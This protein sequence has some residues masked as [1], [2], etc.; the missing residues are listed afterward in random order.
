[1]ALSGPHL[2]E[3]VVE[4]SSVRNVNAGAGLLGFNP[5]QMTRCVLGQISS[6]IKCECLQPASRDNEDSCTLRDCCQEESELVCC[7]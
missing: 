1:M 6:S 5:M 7:T 3:D 4:W 2:S